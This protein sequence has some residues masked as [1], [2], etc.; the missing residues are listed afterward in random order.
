MQPREGFDMGKWFA[1]NG[2]DIRLPEVIG[3]AKALRK[4]YSWV[5]A[6]GYCWGGAIN[7]KLASKD[8]GG[9]VDCVCIA[10]PGGTTEDE[11]RKI[12][13]PIQILAPEHDPTFQ[14]Q[15]RDFCNTE[16]PKL[17]VDYNFQY[18]PGMVHGF[19]TR[20]D[21]SKEAEKRALELAKNAFVY[22]LSTHAK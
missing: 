11:V 22:W 4:Q 2:M 20:C 3:V 15:M 8:H 12:A 17:N 10:H 18:F 14:P 6:V 21:P 16:I 9:L 13:V 1:E 5:G 19:A 7:F